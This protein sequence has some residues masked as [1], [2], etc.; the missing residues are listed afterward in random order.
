MNGWKEVE[1]LWIS[2]CSQSVYGGSCLFTHLEHPWQLL[3]SLSPTS[4][5]PSLPQFAVW[6][7][8]LVWSSPCKYFW[9]SPMLCVLS[10]PFL[11]SHFHTGSAE[12]VIPDFQHNIPPLFGLHNFWISMHNRESVLPTG[13][14][15][16]TRGRTEVGDVES[17]KD[18][19]HLSFRREINLIFRGKKFPPYQTHQRPPQ[20]RWGW[21]SIWVRWTE[22]F[23]NLLGISAVWT[24]P[25]CAIPAKYQ[26]ISFKK[27][28][29]LQNLKWFFFFFFSDPW[30]YQENL[31]K[32]VFRAINTARSWL[33][34]LNIQPAPAFWGSL[35]WLWVGFN[36]FPVLQHLTVLTFCYLIGYHLKTGGGCSKWGFKRLKR[37]L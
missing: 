15:S 29:K 23:H 4:Q 18:Q 9:M 32:M 8:S 24:S 37:K 5:I 26:I 2:C 33:N 25:I 19:S 16:G 36:W 6:S 35:C 7:S 31:K 3:F 28:N 13:A 14:S 17:V 34:L 12:W 22:H 11:R 10:L 30:D 20:L 21:N 27:P 1:F